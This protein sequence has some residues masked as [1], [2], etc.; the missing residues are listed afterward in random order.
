MMNNEKKQTGESM[1]E[2]YKQYFMGP[3]CELDNFKFLKKKRDEDDGCFHSADLHLRI[4][5]FHY[6]APT[7]DDGESGACFKE[8]TRNN[9]N[10]LLCIIKNLLE[11]GSSDEGS[12]E[13]FKA[14]T[15]WTEKVKAYRLNKKLAICDVWNYD[16]GEFVVKKIN[17]LDEELADSCSNK[18]DSEAVQ[19]VEVG[20]FESA[21]VL[22][23]CCKFDVILLDKIDLFQFLRDNTCDVGKLKSLNGTDKNA[24][25]IYDAKAK[26]MMAKEFRDAVK[27]NRGPLDKFWILPMKEDFHKELRENNIRSTDHRWNIGFGVDPKSKPWEFLYRLNE[28]IDLQLRLSVYNRKTLTTFLQYTIDDLRDRL[29]GRAYDPDNKKKRIP[30]TEL[31]FNGFQDFMGA[32]YSNF[33]KRYGARNLV[34]RDAMKKSDEANKSLFCDLRAK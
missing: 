21:M 14:N 33:M 25:C 28:I 32:E 22:L 6:E 18:Q 1:E 5:L 23:S 30:E 24:N 20:D 15:Y 12:K 10:D 8:V 11:E 19:I 4:L 9:Q 7:V 2:K 29:R 16:K 26:E 17:H 27:L 13:S 34:E 3:F 31:F